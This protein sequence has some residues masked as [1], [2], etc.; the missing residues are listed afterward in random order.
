MTRFWGSDFGSFHEQ[1]HQCGR[2]LIFQRAISV[3][4]AAHK[5]CLDS[6]EGI[7]EVIISK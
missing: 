6:Y 3:H 4:P 5:I 1:H 7:G 2:Y